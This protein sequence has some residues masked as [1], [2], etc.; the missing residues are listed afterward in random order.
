MSDDL[1]LLEFVRSIDNLVIEWQDR[2]TQGEI[3]GILLSRVT[4]LLTSDPTIGKQLMMHAWNAFDEL[5]QSNP[6]QYL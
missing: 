3:A 2:Y 6:G 4:L 5:E 1:Q